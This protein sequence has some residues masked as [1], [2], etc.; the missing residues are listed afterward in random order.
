MSR[1]KNKNVVDRKL[2][3]LFAVREFLVEMIDQVIFHVQENN[4]EKRNEAMSDI[5]SII[6]GVSASVKGNANI[7]NNI[8]SVSSKNKDRFLKIVNSYSKFSEER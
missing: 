4:I 7:S 6:R 3:E 2:N 8:E 1:V 5:N